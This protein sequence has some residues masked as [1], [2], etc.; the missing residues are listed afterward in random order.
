MMEAS[1]KE[2]GGGGKLVRKNTKDFDRLQDE[3]KKRN[4]DLNAE[5]QQRE[6]L[7]KLIQDLDKNR[8]IG[9]KGGESAVHEYNE[10]KVKV[11]QQ[12][13]N[14]EKLRK[15]KQKAEE[16]MLVVE[17]KYQNLQEEV[18]ELRK[19]NKKLKK[20]YR[21]AVGDLQ[22]LE[23]E[24]EINREDLLDSIRDQER[25]LKLFY[26]ML[27][28]MIKPEE[29]SKVK[30]ASVWDDNIGDYRIPPFTF[31]EG[32]VKFPKLPANQSRNFF[33]HIIIF[34]IYVK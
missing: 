29:I 26:G 8:V 31:Q 19:I 5:K 11:K 12:H 7:Q 17:K 1:R 13:E 9:G 16:E 30:G 4:E 23:K 21:N 3:L 34:S 2:E 32:K 33:F 15:E 25:D 6:Q 14:E 20:N 27:K 28:I 10:L 24:H 22:D 18:D